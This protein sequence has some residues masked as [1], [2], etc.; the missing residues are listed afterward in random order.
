M[1]VLDKFSFIFKVFLVGTVFLST[2]SRAA[3]DDV[4]TELAHEFMQKN[5]VQGMS[6]ALVEGNSSRIF[7]FGSADSQGKKPVSAN[8]IYEIASFTKTFTATL[9]ARAAI[10]GRLNLDSPFVD[11]FPELNNAQIN[12][13]TSR[14]LLGHVAFLPYQFTPPP[15]NFADLTQSLNQ[16]TPP[17]LPGT[18]YKYSNVGIGIMGYVLQNVYKKK[19]E[20]ILKEDILN[21]L[22]MNS[23][24]L[25]VPSE[26]EKDVSVGI[27]KEGKI[28]PFNKD[29]GPVFATWA[30]KSTIGDMAKYMTA[31]IHPQTISD[32]TLIKA[33]A[34][35]HENQYCFEN[36]VACEQLAW[37]SHILSEL[38]NARSDTFGT[39]KI[40]QSHTPKFTPQNIFIDKTG[41]TYGMSSYMAYIPGRNVGVVILMNKS[42]NDEKIA[43]GRDILSLWIASKK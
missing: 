20:E 33:L 29:I 42:V 4:V 34:L 17:V 13:I 10:E 3:E 25:Y 41:G 5:K 24:Y 18:H 23:T 15:K 40:S 37:Q 6:V 31:Q 19:Y 36:S 32:K 1:T 22:H 27:N 21:P 28:V 38:K 12:S 9:A 16:F 35:V 11:H 43:L 7:Y 26:N 8:T 30:L 2:E 14:Q 39:Q